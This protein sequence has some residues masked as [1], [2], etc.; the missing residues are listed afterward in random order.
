MSDWQI[1]LPG[2]PRRDWLLE[3]RQHGDEVMARWEWQ[4]IWGRESWVDITDTGGYMVRPAWGQI[5]E[6]CLTH[7]WTLHS[8]P[9]E[10]S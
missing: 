5:V 2:E 6:V 7:G 4:F 9:P 10:P 8:V 1:P 3:A